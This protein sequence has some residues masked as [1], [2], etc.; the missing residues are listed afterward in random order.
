MIIVT[1]AT[2]ALNG[3]TVDR[4]LDELPPSDIGVSVRKPEHAQQLADRGV[5]VRQGSYN[6]P[7]ALRHSFADAEQ[8]LLVSSSDVT[9]DVNA[10]HR[11]AIDAA[12]EAGAQRILYTSSHGTGFN[13]PYPPLAINAAAEQ[14][15]AESGVAWT[16][17]RNGFYGDLSQLLGPWQATGTIAKPAD[18]PFSWVDRRD[19]GEAAA[20]I[21]TSDEPFDGPVDL[22]PPTSVTLADF[23]EQASELSGRHVERIVV[24]DEKWVVGEIAAG[25]PEAAARFT[26]A[27][28]QATR[29]GHFAQ[30]GLTL[31]RLLGRE[32][33]SIADQLAAEQ[34]VKTR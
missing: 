1:G 19:A 28:F 24:D 32:P 30:P 12:V 14:H 7:A 33:R 31:S 2:G 29:S 10:Q 13:T 18:G 8:V 15:L 22:T 11:T 23:A 16:A 5:R 26:L 25:V 21:L 34:F 4:L 17:L 9:A 6:D 20:R 27:M 3:V